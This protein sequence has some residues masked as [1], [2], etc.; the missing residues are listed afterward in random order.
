MKSTTLAQIMYFPEQR[1]IIPQHSLVTI[2][3]TVT[4]YFVVTILP[5]I[6]PFLV[7]L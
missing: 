4:L 2:F 7:S 6:I 1:F 5:L 3:A